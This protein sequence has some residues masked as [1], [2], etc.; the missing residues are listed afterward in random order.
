MLIP[1]KALGALRRPL[2]ESGAEANVDI[3][4]GESHLFF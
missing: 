4:K 3:A 1:N 2:R